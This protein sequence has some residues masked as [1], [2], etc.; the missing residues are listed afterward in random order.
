MA[1]E[2]GVSARNGCQAIR[3]TRSCFYASAPEIDDGK[4][5]ALIEGHIRETPRHGF[6]KMHAMLRAKG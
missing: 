1:N 6:D 3:L 4:V 5:I 2:Y